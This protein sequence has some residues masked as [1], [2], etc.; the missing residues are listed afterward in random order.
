MDIKELAYK[1]DQVIEAWQQ[2]IDNYT[3]E[4]LLRKPSADEWSLGQVYIH[5]WMSAK[6]FFF[7]NIQRIADKDVSVVKG[8]RKN[9]LGYLVFLFKRLPRIKIKMPQ[10]V[11]VEP[12]APESKELLHKRMDEVRSL[13]AEWAEKVS[14]L[15]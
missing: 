8:G 7:K 11:A 10:Q 14:Q 9:V 13:V 1:T 12:M 15:D 3:I 6:G 4:Q 5:L 2:D